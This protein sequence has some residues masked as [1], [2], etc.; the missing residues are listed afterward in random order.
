MWAEKLE[1]ARPR[2]LELDSMTYS[3]P[4]PAS[5]HCDDDDDDDDFWGW[6]RKATIDYHGDH[7]LQKPALSKVD[8]TI[9]THMSMMTR[10]QAPVV[11]SKERKS[12][13]WNLLSSR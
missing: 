6:P 8:Q 1:E 13:F 7:D 4:V 5:I 11:K 10:T 3:K 12:S 2:L 9:C